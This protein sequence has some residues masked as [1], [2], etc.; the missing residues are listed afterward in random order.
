MRAVIVRPKDL[1]FTD[2]YPTNELGPASSPMS[3]PS[4]RDTVPPPL[5]PPRHLAD[6][7]DGQSNGHDIAWQWGSSPERSHWSSAVS[8]LSWYWEDIERGKDL[9]DDQ[10]N[11]TRH[12]SSESTAKTPANLSRQASPSPRLDERYTSLSGISVGSN[13]SPVPYE[14][15]VLGKS[16]YGF[17][18]SIYSVGT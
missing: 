2:P 13:R 6:I 1:S 16:Q 15:E 18:P 11:F 3:I 14:Y 4:A 17:E 8:G 7:A 5:P 9:M 10:G 12:R